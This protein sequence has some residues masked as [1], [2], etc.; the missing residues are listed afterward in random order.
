M[1]KKIMPSAKL[2][3]WKIMCGC[4]YRTISNAVV[5]NSKGYE[6]VKALNE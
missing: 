3:T 2:A 6:A 1:Y 5:R 4:E